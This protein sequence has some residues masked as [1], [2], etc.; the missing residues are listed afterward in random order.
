MRLPR[1]LK[2]SPFGPPLRRWPLLGAG[3]LVVGVAASVA[4]FVMVR[5]AEENLARADFEEQAR[6]TAQLV[7]AGLQR[8][9]DTLHA[10][11][12]LFHYSAG[13]SRA[14]F[15]GASRELNSRHAG[16]RALEWVPRV[17]GAQR[18]AVEAA[19]RQEGFPDFEF[20]DRHGGTRLERA[21]PRPEYF[22]VVYIEP[23]EGNEP[24]LGFDLRGG[25]T[26]PIM[27]DI[28]GTGRLA[29][30]GRLPLL[31]PSGRTEWG[32]VMQLPV[33][34][35]PLPGGTD[36]ARRT[37][38]SGFLLGVFHLAP[39]LESFLEPH[40]ER[41][42]DVLFI[43][44]SAGADR[45]FLH[46][47]SRSGVASEAAEAPTTREF[48]TGLHLLVNV[49]QGG[50]TWEL[51][52]RP[53]ASWEPPQGYVK[54]WL[55]FAVGILLTGL[56]G[57]FMLGAL[58]RE[59]E[60]TRL[61][62]ERT[63]ELRDTQH[64]L[65]LELSDRRET[66]RRLTTFVS[67]LP[68][69]AFRCA[70]DERLTALFVSDGMESLTGYPAAEFNSGRVHF[71]ELA[72]AGTDS[73]L[74]AAIARAIGRREPF[75][76]EFRIRDRSG[77]ERWLLVRGRPIFADDGALRFI[78]GLAID[79]TPLKRA[80]NEKIAFERQLLETQ[81][82]ESLGVLAGG[83]AHDFNNLLT[84]ML[85]NATLARLESPA[86]GPVGPYLDQIE[87]AARRA[88]DLCRQMLAYAGRSELRRRGVDLSGLVRSTTVLLRVSVR[89]NTRL[90]L[91]LAAGLPAVLGDAGQLQQ[92]VMNLVI[93]A[94]EAVGAGPGEVHVR[95]YPET[96]DAAR[97]RSAL[98][99]RDR[100]A[101]EYAGC[102][103][104]DS[105]CGMDAA[106]LAR[107]FEPFFTTKFAGRGLGLAAVLGI[108]QRHEG[109]LFVES[110]PGRGSVFR[111]FLRAHGGPVE[112]E[113]TA[114]VPRPELKGEVL[115]VDDEESMRT[116]LDRALRRSGLK[117]R[118]VASGD[119]AL[120]VLAAEPRQFGVVLL[121]L[122]MP[123][124]SGEETL[125]RLRANGSDLPAIVMSGYSESDTMQRVADLG[126]AGFVGKPFELAQLLEKLHRV[127]G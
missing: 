18:G 67:Q 103:V 123:G 95:T 108:V 92:V 106:T 36:E 15:A 5:N 119:E 75:E 52:F 29:A 6:R 53:H 26:W 27:E 98:I 118:T 111:L 2:P 126:V 82:L 40:G 4:G 116:V 73:R 121:D 124:L 16:I 30:S 41:R 8:H 110:Q 71:G 114:P 77:E 47:S 22:P 80:E 64:A 93:N 102:E 87:Q 63:A 9:A 115:V 32:Y 61:V 66:E 107:I 44:R 85:G 99:G 21:V 11:R 65:E 23:M 7:T 113:D 109:V 125:R 68:G 31:T 45:E 90:E 100:P 56:V 3:L 42:L 79:V 12:S 43:D 48:Q 94:A 24:A 117:V 57:N 28:A 86:D 101:G 74:P 20:R 62:T 96:L 60:V 88:S 54:S 97:I 112:L 34:E 76:T 35:W 72:A 89:K 69:A 122:T 84:A 49:D 91:D 33:Y 59:S 1:A 19:V 10:L 17:P 51:W 58:R 13:V 37:H 38:L 70:G 55:T 78:E 46:Y 39:M 127:L 81:K 50:R 25:I 120:A 83:I 14:E 104:R 105:G